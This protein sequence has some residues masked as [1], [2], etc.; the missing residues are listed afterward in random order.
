[1]ERQAEVRALISAILVGGIAVIL[2]ITVAGCGTMTYTP[3]E[4]RAT[5]IQ[6]PPTT[7]IER[8]ITNEK[9]TLK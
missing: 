1:M 8:T 7:I 6:S 9:E 5:T 3:L 4:T 2:L